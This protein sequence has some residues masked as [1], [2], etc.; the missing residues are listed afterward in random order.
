[1][2][3]KRGEKKIRD[4]LM[5]LRIKRKH[6]AFLQQGHL[7]PT[8]LLWFSFLL[9]VSFH[10]RYYYFIPHFFFVSVF[11]FS[12]QRFWGANITA[13][14]ILYDFHQ[15][16]GLVSIKSESRRKARLSSRS[17]MLHYTTPR[18]HENDFLNVLE[19]VSEWRHYCVICNAPVYEIF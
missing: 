5:K 3:G 15:E 17:G 16:R 10:F 14:K 12:Q 1:M 18:N 7:G 9:S 19:W 4:F 13:R 8:L 2:E 11:L 6:Y